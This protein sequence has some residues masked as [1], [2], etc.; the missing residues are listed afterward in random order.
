MNE[1]RQ[2]EN[3]KNRTALIVMA[4]VMIGGM[5]VYCVAIT[6]SA[7]EGDDD[8]YALIAAG[9]AVT[10]WGTLLGSAFGIFAPNSCL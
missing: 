9:F 4:F 10:V 6:L 8:V 2:P 1:I 5:G 3:W 7:L